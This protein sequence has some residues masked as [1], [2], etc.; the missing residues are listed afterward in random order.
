MIKKN[1]IIY[2]AISDKISVIEDIIFYSEGIFGCDMVRFNITQDDGYRQLHLGF[3]EVV[4]EF[5]KL[6]NTGEIVVLGQ[7]ED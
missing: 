6:L 5:A 4:G 1:T 2:G 7:L 3:D